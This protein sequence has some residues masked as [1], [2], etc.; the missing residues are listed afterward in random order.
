ML[1]SKINFTDWAKKRV[2][3]GLSGGVDSVVLLHLLT[4]V[5][6][7]ELSAVY[8]H[9]GLSPNADAWADFCRNYCAQL[10]V[11]FCVEK[12]RVLPEKIGIEAAARLARYAVFRQLS[13]DVVA[14]AH[15]ANDQVETFLLAALRGGGMRALAAM[16]SVRTLSDNQILVRPLLSVT[17]E[18]IVQYAE[19]WQLNWIEDESNFDPK[20]SR[21][22]LR[23]RVL[24]EIQNYFPKYIQQISV[25]VHALQDD[26]ALLDEIIQTDWQMVTQS[27][28]FSGEKWRTLPEKRR[29]YLLREFT[30][31]HDLGAPRRV[32]IENFAQ[33]FS[34][35][36]SAEW[37][38]PK[39]KA[40]VWRDFLFAVP[41]NLVA[42]FLF[43]GSIRAAR[44]SDKIAI[45]N[46]HK[47]VFELLAEMGVPPFARR[48]WAVRV[49]EN[50]AVVAVANGRSVSPD[51]RLW[52][53]ELNAFRLPEI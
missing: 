3:V 11:K 35:K 53:P 22:A 7:G 23:N 42:R 24:P 32:S 20:F 37:G 9:H 46:G 38:L 4:R 47:N 45:Q 44:K 39:G 28:K 43:S 51:A 48:I 34:A 33:I 10:N 30:N 14:L 50:D 21:N 19:N 27:G 29:R 15:H 49:D 31:R 40:V 17:R 12:V 13:C 25:S 52:V 26:L 18:E 2:C 36:T 5:E 6:V 16:P 8:V 41:N 1:L